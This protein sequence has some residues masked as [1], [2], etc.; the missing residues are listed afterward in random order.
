MMNP[1]PLR[2]Q[3]GAVLIVSLMF[4]VILT[5]LGVTAM[6][7][8]T[9]EERMA[10]NARD[11]AIAHHAAEAALREA[12]DEILGLTT[13]KRANSMDRFHERSPACSAGICQKVG[14]IATPAGTEYP[15]TLPP[16]PDI[17]K[18]TKDDAATAEYGSMSGGKKISAVSNQPRYTI[19]LFCSPM[20]YE[21]LKDVGAHCRLYRLTATGWGRNPNT[22]VT[23][24]ET[25]LKDKS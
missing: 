7:S 8:T 2:S 3:R 22:R 15:V 20:F 13:T 17:V 16:I 9:F 6:T 12:R 10:G 5:M 4:L 21:T 11:A 14:D 24:Q 19:E 18:W 23:L 25:F 1:S